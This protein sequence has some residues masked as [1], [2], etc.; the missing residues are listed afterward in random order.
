MTISSDSLSARQ[1][2]GFGLLLL[3][4]V[5]SLPVFWPGFTSLLQAWQLPEYSH[6]PIIP[7]LSF[8]LFLHDLKRVPEPNAPIT[9]RWP[10]L[11]VA[12][13]ALFIA[14]VGQ[15]VRI[16]DIVTYGLILW[17]GALILM[18]MGW[19]RG[20]PMWPGVLH[21]VFMLPLPQFIYWKISTS[22][23]FISSELGVW[24][25]RLLSVP[26]FLEGNIIDLG[27]YKLQVAEACSGLRYLF[28]IMS[29]SYVFCMLYS[30]PRWHKAVL[31][32]SAVPITVLMNSV[33]IA[34]IGVMVDNYGIGMAEG[35]L[36]F[37]EGWVIFAI[38]IAILFGMAIA[39]QRF[40]SDP[41]PLS[42]ALD[43]DFT[44]IRP[45]LA[46][47]GTIPFIRPLAI[48]AAIA[49]ALS[50]A[51]IF[52]PEREA[53]V[54]SRAPFAVFPLSVDGWQGVS[55]RLDPAIEGVLKADDYLDASY[56]K[57]GEGAPVNL[58]MAFY[59]D[60]TDGSGI[61][62][63][64]VCIPGAGWEIK[65]IRPI[66]KPQSVEG[67]ENLQVNRAVITKGLEEMLVYYWFNQRGAQLTNDF[68]AKFQAMKDQIVMG[69]SDGA[70]MRVLT[71]IR[72]DETEADAEARLDAFLA[73]S[74]DQMPR[75]I[76]GAE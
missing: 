64:E 12:V 35:F 69:R 16:N 19:K 13:F 30:G 17:V 4:I 25:L 41:K 71:P 7:L 14:L 33:R 50:A 22:L 26:V 75:F 60:Q 28:P 42:E 62:S 65:N 8:Y 1:P 18:T 34:I 9:D 40:S 23:Q 73:T 51:L 45:E 48:A 36:H 47:V 46:R 20:W 29:F 76:P 11:I 59:R 3:A 39:M 68:K 37:F 27:L 5:A 61:H 2:V 74:L 49:G 10:G 54:P 72:P 63:P 6:G 24:F 43:I 57:A 21:L 53:E 38:C 66:Q 55:S 67:F 31:L 15:L 58:F 52:A 56:V 44:S 32:L 70:L